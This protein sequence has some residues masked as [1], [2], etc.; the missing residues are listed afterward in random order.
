[1]EQTLK[2]CEETTPVYIYL[3]QNLFEMLLSILGA[4]SY[5]LLFHSKK[6]NKYCGII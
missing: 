6:K 3:I 5:Y 1:M 4:F 2:S